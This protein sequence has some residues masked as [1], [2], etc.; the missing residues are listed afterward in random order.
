MD[1][2]I[3]KNIHQYLLKTG[4]TD[5]P[6]DFNQFYETMSSNDSV[7]RA[8]FDYM[9]GREDID[10]LP[11]YDTFGSAFLPLESASPAPVSQE[12][13]KTDVT[14]LTPDLGAVETYKAIQKAQQPEQ[15]DTSSLDGRTYDTSMAVMEKGVEEIDPVPNITDP[16]LKGM[17]DSG[18]G[19][20]VELY[21]RESTMQDSIPV[22]KEGVQN[23]VNITAASM[24]GKPLE[25]LEEKQVLEVINK[26]K[27][28]YATAD[29][30]ERFLEMNNMTDEEG[31]L[32]GAKSFGSKVASGVADPF[33]KGGA[34]LARPLRLAKENATIR[35]EYSELISA[36]SDPETKKLLREAMQEEFKQKAIEIDEEFKQKKENLQTGVK[37]LLPAQRIQDL[38][39]FWM[40]LVPSGIGSTTGLALMGA[41]TPLGTAAAGALTNAEDT[42]Q[43]ATDAGVTDDRRTKATLYGAAIGASE[44]VLGNQIGRMSKL[45]TGAKPLKGM[46]A[47]AVNSSEEFVQEGLAAVLN[48]I[49]AKDYY[50][51]SRVIFDRDVLREAAVGAVVGGGFAVPPAIKGGIKAFKDEANR[52]LSDE[53]IDETERFWLEKGLKEIDAFE[54]E[55][56][57]LEELQPEDIPQKE[58]PKPF[59]KRE[60]DESVPEPENESELET[61]VQEDDEGASSD[62]KL[63]EIQEGS[64]V[65]DEGL[66]LNEQE[67]QEGD[68]G[69]GESD[70]RTEKPKVDDTNTG[71]VRELDETP[72]TKEQS[73]EGDL[74]P[75]GSENEAGVSQGDTESDVDTTSQDG[76]ESDPWTKIESQEP[77]F[78]S[79]NAGNMKIE[80]DE[81]GNIKPVPGGITDHQLQEIAIAHYQV[82]S[83]RQKR[84]YH[85]QTRETRRPMGCHW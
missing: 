27:S 57:E 9:S 2:E 49:N 31:F 84:Q 65:S 51:E 17:F 5:A 44:G 43:E 29:E 72:E 75:V 41:G 26:V 34:R 45:M 70:G 16:S 56:N 12:P 53:E 74:Q 58:Q 68:K 32:S 79:K 50:D 78:V 59:K 23:I 54:E 52:R 67:L 15:V 10:D 14:P 60:K 24:F 37:E 83:Y 28:K 25:E 42:Y 81:D 48:N 61:G 73:G 18:D 21:S 6:E 13:V 35:S 69:S 19:D 71:I 30:R 8:T 3:A 77:T 55:V 62:S 64:P 22:T 80:R 85:R 39:G 76:S 7:R 38:D 66:R 36:V 47:I 4:E 11:D 33:I 82:C 1:Q 63:R 46:R 40:D 20:M